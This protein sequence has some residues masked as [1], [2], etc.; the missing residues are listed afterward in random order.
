MSDGVGSVS[1]PYGEHP[2]DRISEVGWGGGAMVLA[3]IG[4]P[5]ILTSDND[6]IG[7]TFAT[8]STGKYPPGGEIPKTAH[9]PPGEFGM[10]G[11]TDVA[12]LSPS[13]DD[14][15]PIGRF[16]GGLGVQHDR[17]TVLL[18]LK[19]GD[20]Y[21][22]F[23]GR[24]PQAAVENGFTR[25]GI[26]FGDPGSWN[27]LW[28]FVAFNFPADPHLISTD[29]FVY[30]FWDE[31]ADNSG[32]HLIDHAPFGIHFPDRFQN[33]VAVFESHQIG[34][35]QTFA[36]SPMLVN[37]L[38]NPKNP[39]DGWATETKS[40]KITLTTPAVGPI[41]NTSTGFDDFLPEAD[42]SFYLPSRFRC[43]R[44]GTFILQATPTDSSTLW[45][46]GIVNGF[47]DI[48]IGDVVNV[49][50]TLVWDTGDI[51]P[52][53]FDGTVHQLGSFTASAFTPP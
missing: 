50:G 2:F 8:G 42:S 7:S 31:F 46:T 22:G 51:A 40:K 3:E 37:L 19:R 30:K 10:V 13:L 47:N 14:G 25:S 53:P 4:F 5:I 18:P 1:K 6:N 26:F 16:P 11:Y 48:A 52:V 33:W 24:I 49:G 21:W 17:Y 35:R 44:G 29:E 45:D 28:N 34:V 20:V 43:Y 39:P 23:G 32:D 36:I 38:A 41:D 27:A 12:F 15:N 9:P